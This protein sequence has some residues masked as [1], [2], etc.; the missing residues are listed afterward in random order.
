M[1]RRLSEVGQV[2]SGHT[3]HKEGHICT[4]VHALEQE[5]AGLKWDRYAQLGQV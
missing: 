4:D 1:F 5:S 3:F 2:S